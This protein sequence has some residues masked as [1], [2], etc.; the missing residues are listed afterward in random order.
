MAEEI[1]TEGEGQIKALFTIAGNPVLSAPN[2]DRLDRAFKEL[3]FMVSVD[4]YLNE[5]T[6]H[7]DII[8]PATHGLEVAHY[9]VFFNSFAVSNTVK[10]SPP[11]FEKNENQKHDWQILK[12]LS[13]ALTGNGDD[14]STPE[15]I[16]DMA[17]KSGRYKEQGM[18]LQTL[19]DNPHGID[20]GP[21][22]PCAQERIRTGDGRIQLAPEL[23]LNDLPRLTAAMETDAKVKSTFPFDMISRRL[24]RNHN[25]WTHNSHRLIKG[26]NPVTLQ[27]HSDDAKQ[28][29][30]TSGQ[31]VSVR[32]ATGQVEIEV[33]INDDMFQGVV[34]IPQGWGHNHK[35]TQMK[36]AAQQPGISINSLTDDSRVDLLTGNAAFNGTPV[37]ISAA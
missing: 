6:K 21:L 26:K 22:Q 14:K 31:M 8:L 2:G 16:L 9:D 17:L 36:V 25:T 12:G 35:N 1:E 18:S 27:I 23:F 3:D 30:I 24:A 11:M 28:L 20:L 33:E 7:A 37:A 5:T 4:I 10:Y 13:S 29:N 32:S 15:M 19:L 34:S